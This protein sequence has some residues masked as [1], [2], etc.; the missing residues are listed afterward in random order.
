MNYEII[1]FHTHPFLTSKTN[2]CNHPD[3][4]DMTPEYTLEHMKKLGVSKICGSVAFVGEYGDSAWD[5]I[6]RNN[7][8]ALELK[9]LYGDFYVPGFHIHPSFVKESLEEIERMHSMG[10]DLIGELVPYLDGWFDYADKNLYEILKLAEEYGMVLSLHSTEIYKQGLIAK[11][12]PK[13]TVVAAHPGEY[14]DFMRHMECMKECDNYYLDISGYGVFRHGMLRHGLDLFG[15]QRFL[16]GSDYPT[17]N[18]CMYIGA[19]AL[20]VSLS[21]TEKEL[22]LAGNAKRILRL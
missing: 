15:A 8:E 1:D 5:K 17:C 19:V 9:K 12:F 22:I 7:D 3:T 18:P 13:L 2:I 21:E 14:W 11:A 20:D 4:F 6:R 16:Y 10:I